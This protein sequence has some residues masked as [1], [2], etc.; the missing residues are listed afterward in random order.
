LKSKKKRSVLLVGAAGGVGIEVADQ[1]HANCQLICTVRDKSQAKILKERVP[2]VHQVLTLDLSDNHAIRARLRRIVAD[3]SIDLAGVVVC[4]AMCPS[5]PL[6]LASTDD[7]T[8][9]LQVNAISHL[10]I[11][12]ECMA[13]LRKS[14]GR[15]I[16]TSSYSGKVGMPFTG[17]YVAS[18]F[19]LEGLADVMRREANKWGVDIVLIEPGGIKTNMAI[20]QMV[21][22]KQELAALPGRSE[23]LYGDLYRQFLSLVEYSYPVSTS[24]RTVAK[25]IVAALTA[26][27]PKARYPVGPDA[28]KLLSMSTQLSDRQIDLV[29]REIFE[30]AGRAVMKPGAAH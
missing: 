24:A 19:A 9:A 25:S 18:K 14:K 27:R 13:S 2:S 3:R 21:R 17:L 7:L 15:L 1:L 5:G 28:K 11:Y 22:L 4:A 30:N 29:C 12:Q 16:F 6:E 20:K 10:T 23:T 26:R 8:Q